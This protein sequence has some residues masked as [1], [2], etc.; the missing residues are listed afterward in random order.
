MSSN[1]RRHGGPTDLSNLVLLCGQHHRILH[2]L[3]YQLELDAHRTV[4][5]TAPDRT[6]LELLPALPAA[7]A[8]ALPPATPTT[9]QNGYGGDRLDLGYAVNVMPAH[10]A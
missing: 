8:E 3:G 7:S 10:A 1:G 6:L 9:L 2:L 5:V 4:R